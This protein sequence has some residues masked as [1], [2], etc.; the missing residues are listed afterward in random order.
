[1]VL[2][3]TH[4][5]SLKEQAMLDPLV[6]AKEEILAAL[7]AP[8]SE[9]KWLDTASRQLGRLEN[10]IAE[11]AMEGYAYKAKEIAQRIQARCDELREARGNAEFHEFRE[12]VR[13]RAV[14]LVRVAYNTNY[15]YYYSTHTA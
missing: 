2:A 5:P 7:S 1:M 8:A 13:Q 6:Q 9:R 14:E 10:S 4:H 11:W 15:E 3:P 12:R